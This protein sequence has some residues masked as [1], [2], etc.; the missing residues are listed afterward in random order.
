VNCNDPEAEEEVTELLE[1]NS[2]ADEP[3]QA[4]EGEI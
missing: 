4:E 1:G 3:E 2:E